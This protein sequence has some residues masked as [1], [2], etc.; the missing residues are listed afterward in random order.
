[1]EI[2]GLS[3][4]GSIYGE[5]DVDIAFS[6]A[7]KNSNKFYKMQIVDLNAGGYAFVQHWGRIGAKAR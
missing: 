3:G 6:D 1:M 2:S 4:K 5:Y 7:A